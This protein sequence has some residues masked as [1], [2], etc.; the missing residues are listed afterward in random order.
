M[1]DFRKKGKPALFLELACP[2]EFGYSREVL[3]SEF[4][5]K[6]SCLKMGHGGDFCRTDGSLGKKYLINRIKEKNTI[7]GVQLMGFNTKRKIEKQIRKDIIKEIKSRKCAVLH[8]SNVEVDH[9]DGHLDDYENFKPENQKTEQFQPLSKS[10]NCA[11]RQHCK[12]CR[13]TKQ[14]FDAT[15]LGFSKSCWIGNGVY[16]GSCV[17][18]YWH[19]I[20][21]FN[22]KISESQKYQSN[23]DK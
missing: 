7:I 18:C 13:E 3:V 6:Y 14:R 8:I 21:K 17:G 19:D 2:D 1:S 20:R 23:K 12:K 15:V 9:K 22:K 11:K 16:R 4:V 5:G 10:V